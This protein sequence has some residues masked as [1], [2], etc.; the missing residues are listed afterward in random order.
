MDLKHRLK[1]FYY[2]FDYLL[3]LLASKSSVIRFFYYNFFNFSFNREKRAVLHG[4]LHH[5]KNTIKEK[6]VGR[7]ILVRNIHKIEKGLSMSPLRNIF[8][9]S[10]IKETVDIF[11]SLRSEND[12]QIQWANDVL[13]EY[14]KTVSHNKFIKNLYQNFKPI[15]EDNKKPYISSSRVKSKITFEDFEILCKRRRSVRWYSDRKVNIKDVYKAIKTSGLS[16]SACNR[17]PFRYVIIKD[18]KIKIFASKIPMG[19]V[20]WAENIP[21]FCV[22]VGDLSAY[23]DERDR[24]V[25]YID[26]SLAA[27]SFALGLETLG[28]SSCMINWPDIEK[29]ER[30]MEKILNLNKYERPIMCMSVGYSLDDGKIPFSEKK[31]ISNL[32]TII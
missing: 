16:P 2:K 31:E 8:A 20:G 22:I 7:F 28:L 24:H 23:F 14:F 5:L 29:R 30:K 26:S 9:L 19:T 25:I 10:Y 27:M 17:Q 32:I 18:E 11:N 15:K 1:F 3:I 21:L 6:D 13:S 12:K 4:K